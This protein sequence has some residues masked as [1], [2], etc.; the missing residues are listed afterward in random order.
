MATFSGMGTCRCDC[1][2][3]FLSDRDDLNRIVIWHRGTASGWTDVSA[4]VRPGANSRRDSPPGAS[5]R[6]LLLLDMPLPSP[7]SKRMP[8]HTGLLHQSRS[9]FWYGRGGRRENGGRCVCVCVCVCVC[10]RA[11]VRVCACVRRLKRVER[12]YMPLQGL[13]RGRD[14]R[15]GSADADGHCYFFGILPKTGAEHRKP[16][17][18][19]AGRVTLTKGRQSLRANHAAVMEG[20][21]AAHDM[22]TLRTW[23]CR[24]Q[25]VSPEKPPPP[26]TVARVS[27]GS[28]APGV[29][30]S[31]APRLNLTPPARV[32]SARGASRPAGLDSP[33]GAPAALSGSCAWRKGRMSSS[34]RDASRGSS[35][36]AA[37]SVRRAANPGSR[38]AR[39][40]GGPGAA[41]LACPL[42][43][44]MASTSGPRALS[45][46]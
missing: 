6:S 1:C 15:R 18:P 42:E 8:A 16:R 40:P 13:E 25:N 44:S 33:S 41:A 9:D 30:I 36:R 10:A 5:P 29:Y 34:D 45:A 46:R 3:F 12:E 35:L 22:G 20:Q 24:S 32:C 19:H 21:N 26:A 31:R 23:S 38:A 17:P 43:P 28:L 37:W 27:K 11:R 14:L 39:S 2:R 4:S 7:K